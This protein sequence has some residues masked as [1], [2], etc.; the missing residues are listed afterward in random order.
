MAKIMSSQKDTDDSN[1]PLWQ[2]DD[3]EE[4]TGYLLQQ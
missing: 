2:I 4:L 3:G 1:L